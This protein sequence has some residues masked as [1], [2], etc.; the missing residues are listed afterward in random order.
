MWLVMHMTYA[1]K[2]NLDGK[3]LSCD[4]FKENPQG[5]TGGFLNM[6]PAYVGYMLANALSAVTRY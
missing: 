1:N 5:H 4:D 6:V 3:A 2:V